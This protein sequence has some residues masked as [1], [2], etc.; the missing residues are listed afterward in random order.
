MPY[1]FSLVLIFEFILPWDKLFPLRDELLKIIPILEFLSYVPDVREY[2]KNIVVQKQILFDSIKQVISNYNNEL[3][4]KMISFDCNDTLKSFNSD[5][6]FLHKSK[7][8]KINILKK[9][10]Y[11]NYR[12]N[13]NKN[14]YIS[15]KRNYIHDFTQLTSL[16]NSDKFVSNLDKL[17]IYFS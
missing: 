15:K 10:N 1:F 11:S 5:F 16:F 8:T 7:S 4:K 2:I 13:K 6:L 9:K 12:N 14:T 3:K 17:S